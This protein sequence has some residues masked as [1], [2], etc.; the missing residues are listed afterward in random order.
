MQNGDPIYMEIKP[1][2]ST[3]PSTDGDYIDMSEAY[4]DVTENENAT[5]RIMEVLISFF[6]PVFNC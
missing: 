6:I 3:L 5:V 4:Y 2:K 1:R